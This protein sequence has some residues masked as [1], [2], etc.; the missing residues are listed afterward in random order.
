MKYIIITGGSGGIG[1]QITRALLRANY[2]VIVIGRSQNNFDLMAVRL[3]NDQNLSFYKLD[4]SDKN[5]VNTFYNDLNKIDG[6]IFALINAAGVQSPIGK[7]I[8]SDYNDWIINLSNNFL[9]TV[10][11]IRGF[12]F[13]SNN[14]S[15]RKIINF[16]GGGSTSS[17]PNFSAYAV[18]KTA[19]VKFTEILADEIADQ[20]IDINAIAPGAVNTN[21]LDEILAAKS[22]AG[23][24]YSLATKRKKS[25]GVSPKKAVDLCQFLLSEDANGVTGKLISAVWDDYRDPN[26]LAR[27]KTDPEFCCLRRI[28][29]HNFDSVK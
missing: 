6:D 5:S 4:I 18:S 22:L 11:M 9:G 8:N 1:S 29:S 16:S 13:N 7:F 26:F 17:R 15:Q 23:E 25:G 2:H 19:I 3:I 20:N 28:D 14:K 27:L 12:L 24:E 10:N 21:M